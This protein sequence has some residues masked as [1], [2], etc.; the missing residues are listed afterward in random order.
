MSGIYIDQ[1]SH[2]V[3]E[4]NTSVTESGLAGRCRPPS[5]AAD[6]ADAGFAWH[7]VCKPG[8]RAFD[9]AHD[10]VAQLADWAGAGGDPDVT[11]YATALP[12]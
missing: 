1:L 7:H 12:D 8:T 11:V 6:L 10:A 2:A 9:L 4:I 5:P 3:G